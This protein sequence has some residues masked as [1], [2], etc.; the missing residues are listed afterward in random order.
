V[1]FTSGIG[2]AQFKLPG[3]ESIGSLFGALMINIAIF[4][5]FRI[6][7]ERQLFARSP[8]FNIAF[9]G[10][11]PLL[12]PYYLVRTRGMRGGMRA[13]GIAT[14]IYASYVMATL[15]GVMVVRVFRI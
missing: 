14:L 3:Y 13:I 12:L 7:S 8:G 4:A 15:V 1:G 10:I 2:L 5:W 9:V 11:T 6:D